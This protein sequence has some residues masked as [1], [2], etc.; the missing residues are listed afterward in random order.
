MLGEQGPWVHL[1]YPDDDS[2]EDE[3]WLGAVAS[4]H[5]GE[6]AGV[7][8]SYPRQQIA[9]FESISD[10]RAFAEELASSGRWQAWIGPDSAR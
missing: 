1:R 9:R 2:P 5:H 8:E 6:L 4:R 7:M 3:A 10:A